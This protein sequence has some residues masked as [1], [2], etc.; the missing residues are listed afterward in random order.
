M[1]RE[2]RRCHTRNHSS[3]ST[4]AL[5]G[6]HTQK[7]STYQTSRSQATW[8]LEHLLHGGTTEGRNTTDIFGEGIFAHSLSLG[9]SLHRSDAV[10]DAWG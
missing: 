10:A 9:L 8:G 4:R 6:C 7:R 3:F 2:E 1:Q 5:E